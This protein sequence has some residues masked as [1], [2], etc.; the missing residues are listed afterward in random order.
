V[1]RRDNLTSMIHM[2]VEAIF[3]FHPLIWC[4]ERQLVKERERARDEDV[5]RMCGQPFVY[6][7]AILKVC[8]FC[9]ASPPGSILGITG[10]ELKRRVVQIMTKHVVRKLTFG[11][12]IVLAGTAVVALSWPILSGMMQSLRPVHAQAQ[13]VDDTSGLPRFDV[14]SVRPAKAG[15]VRVQDL[16]MD[17]P[18]GINARANT[19][20]ELI[21]A[22]Y[23]GREYPTGDRILGAPEWT[24]SEGFYIQAKV[25]D[26]DLNAFQKLSFDQR[27]RMLRPILIDRF[28][29]KVHRETRQLPV[30][31][32]VI[33]KAEHKLK[34]ARADDVRPN[35][36]KDVRGA[37]INISL[38]KFM[39]RN[40]IVAQATTMASLVNLLAQPMFGLER[41][42]VDKTGLAGTYDFALNW[43]P[44]PMGN[45]A[46]NLDD[47]APAIF[48]ALREQLGL[49]LVAAKG[50]VEALVIDSV[51]RPTED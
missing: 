12:K 16:P 51:E 17:M 36:L 7:E 29:L 35:G 13:A 47:S 18:D 30:Y 31:E 32:L 6:A 25:S 14:V 15:E 21:R 10:S 42:V 28:K 44:D 50:P 45:E 49:R 48:S 3:W 1:K 2:L 33:D 34:E 11:K 46:P 23:G 19:V 4:L 40:E 39:G 5:L 37:P 8:E 24:R 26:A 38:I 41:P 20:V 22:A 43:A 9:V 27:C